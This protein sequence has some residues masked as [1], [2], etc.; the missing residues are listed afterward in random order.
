MGEEN[1]IRIGILYVEKKREKN[2]VCLCSNCPQRI[3]YLNLV[4]CFS[5]FTF[6]CAKLF[7]GVYKCQLTR[8]ENLIYVDFDGTIKRLIYIYILSFILGN[9]RLSHPFQFVAQLLPPP[10][11]PA[12]L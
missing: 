2:L 3:S 7:F 12:H 8:Q 1:D 11:C 9:L 10:L 6:S 4:F 5:H